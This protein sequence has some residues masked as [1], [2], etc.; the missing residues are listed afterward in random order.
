MGFVINFKDHA[1]RGNHQGGTCIEAAKEWQLGRSQVQT[2]FFGLQVLIRSEK[3]GIRKIQPPASPGSNL[4][5][6]FAITFR[7][8]LSL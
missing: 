1:G 3:S 2:D 4:G 7:V 8:I 6:M 5:T